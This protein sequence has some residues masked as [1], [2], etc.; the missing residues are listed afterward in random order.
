MDTILK[1]AIVAA[2]GFGILYVLSGTMSKNYNWKLLG[3][4]RLILS[5]LEGMGVLASFIIGAMIEA[6]DIIPIL[7]VI[8][9]IFAVFFTLQGIKYVSLPGALIIG[10]IQSYVSLFVGVLLIFLGGAKNNGQTQ[11]TASE[12]VIDPIRKSTLERADWVAKNHGYTGA[13]DWAKQNGYDD[14]ASAYN[15]GFFNGKL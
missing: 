10:V 9:L 3:D 8:W 6:D 5:I 2:I 15:N 13:E 14:A 7:V 12:T 1:A 11:N 4:S